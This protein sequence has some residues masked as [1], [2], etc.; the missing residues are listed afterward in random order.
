MFSIGVWSN[1]WLQYAVGTSVLLLLAVVYVP[2]IQPFF[3]TVPLSLND[4][5][6]MA[7]FIALASVA[8]EITKWYLRRSSLQLAAQ[9]AD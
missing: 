8:A 7:P 9:P 1:R 3:N 4:W 6:V 5:I 2:F